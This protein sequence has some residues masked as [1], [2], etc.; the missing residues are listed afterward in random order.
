MSKYP[1]QPLRV[2]QNEI[3]LLRLQPGSGSSGIEASLFCASSDHH[4]E[5]E[6]LSYAWGDPNITNPISLTFPSHERPNIRVPF[7]AAVNLEQA[8][9]H[10]R[11]PDRDRILWVDAISINQHDNAER[12]DQVRMMGLIYQRASRV[13]VWLGAEADCSNDAMDLIGVYPTYKTRGLD[14]FHDPKWTKHWRAFTY[15]IRRSWFTRCWIVQEVAL[16]S[17]IIVYCGRKAVPWTAFCHAGLSLW[18]ETI[19]FALRKE[20]PEFEIMVAFRDWHIDDEHRLSWLEAANGFSDLESVLCNFK[21]GVTMKNLLSLCYRQAASDPRDAVFSLI[22][23]AKETKECVWKIDYSDSVLNCVQ[24]AVEN[25]VRVSNSLDIICHSQGVNSQRKIYQCSWLPRFSSSSTFETRHCAGYSHRSLTTL[26]YEAGSAKS[27]YEQEVFED[28][29][30]YSASLDSKPEVS[31]EKL[32]F[33]LETKGFCIDRIKAVLDLPE[34]HIWKD[35]A[36][37]RQ[38]AEVALDLPGGEEQFWRT[39]TADRRKVL[40]DDDGNVVYDE[41]GKPCGVNSKAPPEW[42]AKCREWM[43]GEMMVAQ[44]PES[45]FLR[46]VAS[47][48]KHKP[49]MAVTESSRLLLGPEEAREGDVVFILLGC[50]VPLLLRKVDYGSDDSDEADDEHEL[51]GECYVHGVMDGEGMTMLHNGDYVLEQISLV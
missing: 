3:R 31:F 20:N 40:L 30:P 21:N 39:L 5:Y 15:L 13:C 43:E 48:L 1:Y 22:S 36:I 51:V 7:D 16:A 44:V 23:M 29:S 42:G 14:L 18:L 47:V 41:T 4:P 2:A 26:R 45:Q 12:A 50:S 19:L 25:I 10:L 37:P 27:G 6:A 24:D 38:W 33:R 9:R 8:L 34:Y 35:Y 49:R 17:D 11:L 28:R 32:G 46:Q